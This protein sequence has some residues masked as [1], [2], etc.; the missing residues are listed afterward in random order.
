[1]K[2]EHK[3]P[4]KLIIAAIVLLTFSACVEHVKYPSVDNVTISPNP[5]NVDKGSTSVF[6]ATIKGKNNPPQAVNWSI[7]GNNSTS[8]TISNDGLLTVSSEETATSITVSAT[9]IYDSGKNGVAIV[10]IPGPITDPII[11]NVVVSPNPVTISRGSQ[12][13]FTAVVNGSNNPPQTVTW[14]ITGNNSTSTTINSSSGI[15]FVA[16]GETSPTITVRATSTYDPSIIGTAI[17]NIVV[18][19][20][21]NVVV[22]PNPVNISW[23]SQQ[24]FT[25]VV[26]G[27]NNPP[28]TVTWSITGNNSSSTTI[29]SYGVLTVASAETSSIIYVR[30]TSTYNTNVSGTATANI[31]ISVGNLINFGGR[32]WRVLNIDIANNRALIISENIIDQRAYHSSNTSIRWQNCSLR[33]YLNGNFYNSFS[34]TDRARIQEVTNQ[35]PNNP[36]YDTPGGSS[37]LDKIFLLSISEAQQYFSNA[38]RV[39][40][41]NGS[42]SW[43]WLRSPGFTSYNASSVNSDGSI[44][45]IGDIV[46]LTS[47]GV[48]PALWLN[49]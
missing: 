33:G 38:G 4:L 10:N 2:F 5:V 30:A 21:N 27:S 48:R 20:V 25:A 23:G 24:P 8:T 9:S 28:Q 37:T 39:A 3:I 7:T 29:N 22:S 32:Q 45:L 42:A 40:Y 31:T 11:D 36:M 41:Y 1:M 35:N 44:G 15:L 14:N 17:A 19:T 49:L 34:A 43:W 18:P 47:G 26:N 46:N 6:K 12:Q 13:P 16:S